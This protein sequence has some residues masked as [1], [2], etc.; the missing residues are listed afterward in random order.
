MGNDAGPKFVR[1]GLPLLHPHSL[2]FFTME[3]SISANR[4]KRRL[5]RETS[6]PDLATNYSK[7]APSTGKVQADDAG[8]RALRPNVPE[9][10]MFH[11]I[12]KINE[13]YFT[14][15]HQP[16]PFMRFIFIGNQSAGKSTIVER[17]LQFPMNVVAEGTGTRCPLFVTTTHDTTKTEPVCTLSGC[18]KCEAA[19][20]NGKVHFHHVFHKITSHNADHVV[21]GFSSEALR[22][23]VES[24]SV[25]NMIFVDLP[26]IA[27]GGARH[28]SP[29]P[30]LLNTP[31]IVS[32]KQ[33]LCDSLFH[34]GL[35][36]WAI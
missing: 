31:N 7:S 6:S 33:G 8:T 12:H 4:A 19:T 14:H 36:R 24:P 9:D 23:H 11:Y 10:D 27:V 29:P 28:D 34:N 13:F 21:G 30:P 1:P 26:G 16:S 15:L 22:L 5:H 32:P 18:P 3:G 20:D 17:I 35:R 2:S 25:P